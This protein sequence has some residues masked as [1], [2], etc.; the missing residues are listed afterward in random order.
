M[1]TPKLQLQEVLDIQ[2]GDT[3]TTKASYVKSGYL[4]YSATGPDGFLDKYDYDRDGIVLSAIGANCG[5]T[6]LAT[7]KWSCIK[8]TIR[9][10]PKS[11]TVDLRYFYYATKAPNFWPIRGSAQPFISQTDIREMSL[12]FPPL[13]VQRKIGQILFDLDKK[14]EVNAAIIKTLEDISAAIYKEWFVDFNS[15]EERSLG[16]LPSGWTTV[17]L[18]EISEISK[19]TASPQN[20]PTHNF[21]LFSIPA[22]DA[23]RYPASSLGNE[24]LSGKF[25]IGEPSVLVSKLNPQ[26]PRI[27]TVSSPRKNA[28]CSTEFIVL[29]THRPN[30][31]AFLNQVVRSSNF[32]DSFVSMATGSTGS[33]QRVRP[34]DILNIKITLPSAELLESFEEAVGPILDRIQILSDQTQVLRQIKEAILPRLFSG[35]LAIPENMLAA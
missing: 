34:G 11:D 6:F 24:I 2:W 4:A 8:N 29:V 3:K 9:I 35:Q 15:S 26:T 28:V 32:Q 16:N 19:E 18:G 23:T 12:T 7:G 33:R 17:N 22:F 5:S 30:M 27:W 13:E 31:F 21:D 20:H 14:L 25:R 1:A 10:L